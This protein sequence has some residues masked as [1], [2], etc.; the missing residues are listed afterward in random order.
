MRKF[1][2]ESPTHKYFVHNYVSTLFN[3][4]HQYVV[5]KSRDSLSHK[6]HPPLFMVIHCFLVMRDRT[7]GLCRD[8]C[9]IMMAKE[10]M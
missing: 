7:D 10:S 8:V 3:F 2:R 4:P 1:W 5:H 9:N 6:P